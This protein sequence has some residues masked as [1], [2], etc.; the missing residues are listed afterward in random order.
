MDSEV[1]WKEDSSLTHILLPL[2]FYGMEVD[3]NEQLVSGL[4]H[5][6]DFFL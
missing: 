5:L 1:S 3:E 2:V 6:K 4:H